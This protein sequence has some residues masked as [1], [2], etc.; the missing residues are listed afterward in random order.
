MSRI[1]EIADRYV[2]EF[3]ALDPNAATAS[4]I[5]GHEAEMTDYS[6][7]GAAA[8]RR[9]RPAHGDGTGDGA[10]RRRARP[11]RPRRDDWSASACALDAYDAGEYLR[12]LRQLAARCRACATASTRCRARRSRTGRTSRRGS[13]SCRARSTASARRCSKGC[14]AACPRRSARR[15]SARSRPRSGAARQGTPSF[16]STLLDAYDATP[17]LASDALRADLESGVRASEAAYAA[18]RTFLETSTCRTR[19]SATRRAA[20]AT[21]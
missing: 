11:H 20:S 5:A 12:A 3:A 6:P 4:G 13:T 1:F 7:D 15:A 18:M 17:A 14:G 9:A 19:R 2:D 8:D 10:G 21:S 16:F